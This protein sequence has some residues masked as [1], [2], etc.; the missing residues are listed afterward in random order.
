MKKWLIPCLITIAVLGG[1]FI[2]LAIP[3]ISCEP[4]PAENMA[5]VANVRQL[6]VILFTYANEKGEFPEKISDLPDGWLE[7]DPDLL[8]I[9]RK[10]HYM[11]PSEMTNESNF[12]MLV[13]PSKNGTA[14]AYSNTSSEFI[15]KK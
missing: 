7:G 14:V 8:K 15:R 11:K 5:A 1:L 2:L 10:V 9:S 12:I 3:N 13:L 4:T 6:A